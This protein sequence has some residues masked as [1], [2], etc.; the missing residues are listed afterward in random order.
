M[1]FRAGISLQ[2]VSLNMGNVKQR[3]G[4]FLLRWGRSVIAGG[5]LVSVETLTLPVAVSVVLSLNGWCG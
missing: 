1:R 2:L 4:V 3:R 5:Q